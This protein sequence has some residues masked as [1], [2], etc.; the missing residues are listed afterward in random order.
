MTTTD[1]MSKIDLLEKEI[2]SLH[3]SLELMGKN[4]RGT[5]DIYGRKFSV[6][7]CPHRSAVPLSATGPM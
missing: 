1:M 2:G 5:C 7:V 4:S 3:D 6:P